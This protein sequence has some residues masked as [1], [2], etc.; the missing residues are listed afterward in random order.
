MISV[1]RLSLRRSEAIHRRY[2]S[3]IASSP[4]APRNDKKGAA[5]RYDKRCGA[6]NDIGKA[7]V[8]ASEAKQSILSNGQ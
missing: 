2:R 4:A 8:I 3:W 6:F 5:P 7:V 1:E